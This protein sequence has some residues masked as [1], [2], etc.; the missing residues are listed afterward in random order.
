M[1]IPCNEFV[2]IVTDYLDG[3][4]APDLATGIDAHLEECP[5]CASVLEQFRETIRQAGRL[6]IA[7][8]ETVDPDLRESLMEAFAHRHGSGT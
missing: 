8:V 6:C 7:D 4:L 1:S 2:E 5:G 3:A